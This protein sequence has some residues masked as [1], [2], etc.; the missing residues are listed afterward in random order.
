MA[1]AVAGPASKGRSALALAAWEFLWNPCPASLCC[2][3]G[4]LL[5]M[6][7]AKSPIKTGFLF[8][9]CFLRGHKVVTSIPPPSQ[10]WPGSE[11]H[12]KPRHKKQEPADCEVCNAML[13]TRHKQ[14]SDNRNRDKEE[15]GCNGSHETILS[16]GR[17]GDQQWRESELTDRSRPATKTSVHVQGERIEQT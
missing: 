7:P 3:D 11:S 4:G 9:P 14:T 8:H 12:K 6:P 17:V 2:R 10:K 5:K 13:P 16:N 15:C 1:T